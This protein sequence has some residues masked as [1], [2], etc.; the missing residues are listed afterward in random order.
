M[1]GIQACLDDIACV[2]VRADPSTEKRIFD[3]HRSQGFHEATRIDVVVEEKRPP[4]LEG[5]H[6]AV[7]IEWR[8]MER[9]RRETVRSNILFSH[10]LKGRRHCEESNAKEKCPI[11][12]FM[13][14]SNRLT[15]TPNTKIILLSIE[16]KM[17][18][19]KKRT[20]ARTPPREIS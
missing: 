9:P 11:S 8:E 1:N 19:L 15:K 12:C 2:F 3:T 18:P 4:D 13:Q 7:N 6:E 10:N 17:S 5:V 14:L 20:V 16:S